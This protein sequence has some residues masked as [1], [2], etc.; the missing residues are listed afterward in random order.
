MEYN[1]WNEEV[2]MFD[3]LTIAEIKVQFSKSVLEGLAAIVW[4]CMYGAAWALC[5]SYKIIKKEA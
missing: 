1:P 5:A 2:F 3:K 4:D